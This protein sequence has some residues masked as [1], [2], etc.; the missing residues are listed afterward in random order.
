[1]GDSG[2]IGGKEKGRWDARANGCGPAVLMTRGRG[3][4]E[5]VCGLLVGGFRCVRVGSL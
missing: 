3:I 4:E 5:T 1:M 2:W